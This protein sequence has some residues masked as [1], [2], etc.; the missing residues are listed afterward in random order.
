MRSSLGAFMASS[1]LV[2]GRRKRKRGRKNKG[3]RNDKGASSSGVGGL[4]A[5]EP[6]R[7]SVDQQGRGAQ[8]P[9]AHAFFV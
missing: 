2:S 5:Q 7:Q 6:Y 3:A 8:E 9:G 1:S 4:G